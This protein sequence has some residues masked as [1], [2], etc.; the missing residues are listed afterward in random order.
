MHVEYV[1]RQMSMHLE[2]IRPLD[3]LI[4]PQ[5]RD[6]KDFGERSLSLGRRIVVEPPRELAQDRVLAV[7]P[8]AYDEG[9]TEL[10][11]VGVVEAM[12]GGEFLFAQPVEARAGLLGGGIRRQLA[13]TRG[14]AGKIGVTVDQ[15]ALAFVRALRTAC[16]I[17]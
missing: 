5:R 4:E 13:F 3:A 6:A 1:G 12:E 7:P 17:T 14:F 2:A 10:R 9:H 15:R 11:T 8:Y 16:V